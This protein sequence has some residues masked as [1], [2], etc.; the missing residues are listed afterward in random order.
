MKSSSTS[1][2]RETFTDMFR[3]RPPA[4]D[5]DDRPGADGRDERPGERRYDERRDG[6][7][8][9]NRGGYGNAYGRGYNNGYRSG[10]HWGYHHGYSAGYH[11]GHRHYYGPS[12]I[13]GYHYGGFGFYRGRWHFALVIG[14]PV[15]VSHRHY[16]YNYDYAWWDGRPA[17]LYTWDRATQVYPASYNFDSAGSCVSLWIRTV[18][19]DDYE[20]K[21]DPRYWNVQDPG[22]LYAALWTELEREGRLEL[23]DVNGAIHVFPAEMIQQIEATGC[24]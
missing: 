23:E 15:I 8:D 6:R 14:G 4:G 17:S 7:R 3:Q 20:V 21:I 13:F 10:Y 24:R 5:R 16:H 11:Y 19:G 2:D 22:Q 1:S 9:G 18:D 12:L